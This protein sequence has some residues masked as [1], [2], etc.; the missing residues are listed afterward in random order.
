MIKIKLENINDRSRTAWIELPASDEVIEEVLNKMNAGISS[1]ATTA[2]GIAEIK[3]DI[4]CVDSCYAS[5]VT[6]NEINLLAYMTENMG[7]AARQELNLMFLDMGADEIYC[8][9]NAAFLLKD[10]IT[11]GCTVDYEDIGI[12]HIED[13]YPDFP[14]DMHKYIDFKQVAMDLA[15]EGTQY[16]KTDELLAEERRIYEIRNDEPAETSGMAMA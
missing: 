7:E 8:Q 9:I 4:P 5:D 15:L 11:E 12:K 14:E 13:K 1:G 16:E 10:S 6:L 3:S 2:Y